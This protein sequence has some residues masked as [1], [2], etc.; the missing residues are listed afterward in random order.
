MD[1]LRRMAVFA[2][3]VDSAGFSEAARK[4]GITRSAVSRQVA[5][6]ED[7]LGARLLNRT[8]R[9]LS[10]TEAG[11]RYYRSCARIVAEAAAADR[12]VRNLH[13]EPI[14]TLKVNGPVIGSRFLVEVAR[15]L[16]A[17]YPT[18]NVDLSLEDSYINLVE[19]GVEK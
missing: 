18:L 19:E 3:V 9:R 6:L 11:D 8:T 2:Q 15:R 14:G 4:L 5:L 17:R 7:M 16:M 13:D 10:L 12:A 1:N